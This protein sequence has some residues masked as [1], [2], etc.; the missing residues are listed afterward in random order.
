MNENTKVL[1]LVVTY[2]RL[3]LL[4]KCIEALK[5][6]SYKNYDI[7]V[8]NNG[9]TDGTREYLD[10]LQDVISIHQDNL[11]GAGGFGRG[12]EF[13]QQ[14][15]EYGA[16]WM[17]DDDGIPEENQLKNILYYSKKNNVDYANALVLNIDDHSRLSQGNVPYIFEDYKNVEFIPSNMV[18]FNGTLVYRHVIDKIGIVKKEMFIW[19]DEREYTARVKYAGYRYGTITKAIHYHPVLRG[20]KGNAIPFI[21]KWKLILKPLGKD[22]YYYRNIGYICREYKQYGLLLKYT[23]YYLTRLKLLSYIRFMKYFLLG[24]NNN[25]KII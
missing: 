1:A 18:P 22:K 25:F 15:K 21:N 17:M 13:V 24:Y 3:P 10:S 23:C 19:G 12:M 6:Q 9:S 16:I 2:N 11:G 20:E 4:K 5:L 8:V 7:L 14:N